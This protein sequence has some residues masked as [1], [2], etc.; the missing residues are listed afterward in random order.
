MILKPEIEQDGTAIEGVLY[1]PNGEGE[2][3]TNAVQNQSEN[4]GQNQ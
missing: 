4:A 3:D 2:N 1:I